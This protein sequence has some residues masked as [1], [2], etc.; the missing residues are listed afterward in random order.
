MRGRRPTA[1][2]L[3]TEIVN[4]FPGY[5]DGRKLLAEVLIKEGSLDEAKPHVAYL[6][7]HRPNDPDVLKMKLQISDP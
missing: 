5:E 2:R 1:P 7:G 6:D 4:R 3:L